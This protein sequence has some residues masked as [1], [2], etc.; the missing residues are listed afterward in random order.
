MRLSLHECS[1]RLKCLGDLRH[2]S[3]SCLRVLQVTPHQRLR[4]TVKSL[5]NRTHACCRGALSSAGSSPRMGTSA[6]LACHKVL[7]SAAQCDSSMI[8]VLPQA[9]SR[10]LPM[11]RTNLPRLPQIIRANAPAR[12]HLPA[13]AVPAAAA[14]KPAV[15]Y[16]F[17]VA[18]AGATPTAAPKGLMTPVKSAWAGVS[19][20]PSVC[21]AS[22]PL[23]L[24]LE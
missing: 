22:P 14:A 11:P 20:Q 23:V 1:L 7:V 2:I 24:L 21:C 12:P 17:P 5:W 9:P 10:V 13:R 3:M 16:A 4:T 19:P 8:C 6:F 18:S 15:P